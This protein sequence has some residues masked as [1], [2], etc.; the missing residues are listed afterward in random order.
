M[1][2]KILHLNWFGKKPFPAVYQKIL[3]RWLLLTAETEWEIF[4]WTDKTPVF[5]D[6]RSLMWANGG[7]PVQVSDVMRFGALYL[8]GGVYLDF[9]I[10]PL[11]LPEFENDECFNLFYEVD[12]DHNTVPSCATMASPKADEH[13]RYLFWWC[14]QQ[15]NFNPKT[16]EERYKAGNGM[17]QFIDP[18]WFDGIEK[19]GVNHYAPVNWAQARVLNIAYRYTY[20]DWLKLAE[21]FLVHPQVYGVHTYDSSWVYHL[22][23]KMEQSFT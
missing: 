21:T 18:R 9:D 11:R 5:F 7:E 17:F 12:G 2:P 14:L 3:D 13:A 22:N 23:S 4:V 10:I 8:Y 16:R 6:L 20:D 15:I 19:R 1:I